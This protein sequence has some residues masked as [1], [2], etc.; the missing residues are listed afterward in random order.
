MLPG[1]ARARL[2]GAGRAEMR[3]ALDAYR[4]ESHHQFRICLILERRV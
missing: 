1:G 2:G 3:A 4:Q